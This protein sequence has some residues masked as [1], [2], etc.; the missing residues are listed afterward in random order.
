MC[1]ACS[2]RRLGRRAN[3]RRREKYLGLW[4]HE[5][6]LYTEHAERYDANVIRREIAERLGIDEPH[7]DEAPALPVWGLHLGDAIDQ[8]EHEPKRRTRAA[9]Q[10][11]RTAE[12]LANQQYRDKQ[13]A[14]AERLERE[15][16][17][18]W[19]A[20]EAARRKYEEATH[21]RA[22][23]PPPT[24]KGQTFEEACAAA[25]EWMRRAGV[26]T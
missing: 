9:R 22:A 8:L 19:E 18:A 7:N 23:V 1:R 16:W 14:E 21:A 5:G 26:L 20:R 2:N 3:N 17:E 11:R 4:Q 15:T 25:N 24:G 13:R 6:A 10:S 12:Q